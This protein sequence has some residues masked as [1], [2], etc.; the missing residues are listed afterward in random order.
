MGLEEVCLAVGAGRVGSDFLIGGGQCDATT[1]GAL[2]EALHDEEGFVYF[3]EGGFVFAEGG[4]EGFE[5]T[6]AALE[7]IDEIF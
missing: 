5:S 6:G 2:E 7:F 4:G 1:G 3:F